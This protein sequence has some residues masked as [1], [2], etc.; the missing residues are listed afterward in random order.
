MFCA[1]AGE[2]AIVI[3][4]GAA[5]LTGRGGAA[6]ARASVILDGEN[7]ENGVTLYFSSS[8]N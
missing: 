8:L 7:L 1:E 6:L 5:L 2:G 4:A 3:L